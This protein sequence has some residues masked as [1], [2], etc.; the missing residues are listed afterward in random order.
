MVAETLAGLISAEPFE[1]V[2]PPETPTL[3]E[4]RIISAQYADPIE[5]QHDPSDHHE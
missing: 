1:P 3:W 2:I 4:V 5:K